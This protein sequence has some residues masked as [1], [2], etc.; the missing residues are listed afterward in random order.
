RYTLL[1]VGDGLV[2]QIPALLIS[3]ATGIIITRAASEDS[4]GGDVTGQMMSDPKVLLIA[5]SVL[6]GFGLVP[7]LPAAPFMVLAL[8]MAGLGLVGRREAAAP[9]EDAAAP[10]SPRETDH[11]PE[12]VMSLLH[13]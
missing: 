2:T 6:F 5:G 13:V 10:A 4:L 9:A 8:I 7:G 1:T 12:S 3:T 11:R